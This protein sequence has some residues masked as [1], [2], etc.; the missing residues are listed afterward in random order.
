MSDDY[1]KKLSE[2][3]NWK[4]KYDIFGLLINDIPDMPLP[5]PPSRETPVIDTC[6]LDELIDGLN[7]ELE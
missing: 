1:Y 3:S 2:Y 7:K 4:P 5:S 6:L